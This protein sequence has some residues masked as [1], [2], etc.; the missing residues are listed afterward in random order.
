MYRYRH[1][2]RHKDCTFGE[3]GKQVFW[4]SESTDNQY[5]YIYQN[6]SNF[7]GKEKDSE[8]GY[9]YFGARYLDQDM[10]TLFL[11]V[12][13]MT[14]KYPSINPYAYC[15][16]NPIKLIDPDGEEIWIVNKKGNRQKYTVGMSSEG[17]DKYTEE[18]I[19]ALNRL[20][21][22]KTIGDKIHQLSYVD[23]ISITIQENSGET[24][25]DLSRYDGIFDEIPLNQTIM[26]DPN[27]GIIDIS[28]EEILSPTIC[29]GHEF[30]HLFNAF[31][32]PK[33]YF[34]RL[35]NIRPDEWDNNE[36]LFNIINVEHGLSIEFNEL[37]REGHNSLDC[38]N[39]T[40]YQII[41]INSTYE[42]TK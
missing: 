5:A 7:T 1:I 42:P 39:N 27:L 24:Y 23:H 41:N 38:N 36:E 12:D 34:N 3:A 20:S 6:N 10:T 33:E 35:Y 26:F 30:G 21:T 40:R 9:Y 13:P 11:S 17:F 28:T 29:L 4:H 25:W 37:I 18:T 31:E 14:D 32:N 15:M 2:S 16:W 19:I 8:S 22:T